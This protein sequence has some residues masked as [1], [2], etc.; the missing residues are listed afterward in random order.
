[1][2]AAVAAAAAVAVAN[3]IA[4][5]VVARRR[6]RHAVACGERHLASRNELWPFPGTDSYALLY[7]FLSLL[8]YILLC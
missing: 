2:A 1:M 3:A 7:L 8:A 6:T 5:V 4:A